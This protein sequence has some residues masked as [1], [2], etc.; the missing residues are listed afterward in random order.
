MASY[1]FKPIVEEDLP[2]VAAF[3]Y[4]QQEI[5]SR[6]DWTQARPSG[7]DLRGLLKNPHLRP[8]MAL[9]ETLRTPEGKILGMILALPRMY[10]LGERRLLGLAAGNFY[11][12]SSARMQGFFLLRRFLGTQGVDFWYA[13]S[14]NRQSGPLWAKCGGVMVPE[15]DLEY[16]FP[17]RLGPLA[18]E[19]AIRKGWPAAVAGLLRAAGSLATPVAAPRGPKNRLA[20][21]YCV[22]L[23]RLADIAERD[24]DPELLQPGRSV[25]YLQWLY[26]SL[27]AS[28]GGDDAKQVIYRFADQAGAEGW[29][30]LNFERRGRRGPDPQRAAERRRLAVPA[31]VLRRRAP[32]HHRGGPAPIRPPEHPGPGRARAARGIDGTAATAAAGAGRIP[33]VPHSPRHRAGQGG[34]FP[35]RRPLLTRTDGQWFRQ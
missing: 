15:S 26:G 5:T 20:L 14:C 22:D 6:A 2:G 23:E 18:Q 24:R 33:R 28:P 29:F 3:L 34:R 35:V 13:N 17:F 19:L 25:P 12:D 10:H 4:E 7:D 27:P 11:V 32:G 30:V 21:E 9:G 31:P 1:E 16:L 8:G